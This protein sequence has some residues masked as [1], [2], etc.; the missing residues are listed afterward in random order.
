[1]VQITVFEIPVGFTVALSSVIANRLILN[2]HDSQAAHRARTESNSL[3]NTVSRSFIQVRDA[4]QPAY[5]DEE[6]NADFDK[7]LGTASLGLG[8]PTNSRMSVTLSLIGGVGPTTTVEDGRGR[9]V[10][11]EMKKLR[12]LRV[13]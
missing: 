6:S 4:Q 12:K 1:M 7:S 8:S 3:S 2:L 11:I 5:D 13:S 9:E 10:P